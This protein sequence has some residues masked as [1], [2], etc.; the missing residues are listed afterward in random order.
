MAVP[1]YIYMNLWLELD[2]WPLSLMQLVRA[3]HR[4]RTAA[5][6]IPVRGLVVAFVTTAAGYV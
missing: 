6:S 5:G 1:Q 4:N 2:N 3:L